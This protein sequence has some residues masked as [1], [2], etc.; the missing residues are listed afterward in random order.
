MR[1][2]TIDRA[3][4]RGPRLRTC[5]YTIVVYVRV[6]EQLLHGPN[7]V[8]VLEQVCREGV[9]ERV[10]TYSLDD[11]GLPRRPG[12][13]L[14]PTRGGETVSVVPIADRYRLERQETRTAIPIRR[15][16]S[17]TCDPA[18]TVTRRVQG[19]VRGRRGAHRLVRW[20]LSLRPACLE[21]SDARSAIPIS[22]CDNL[23]MVYSLPCGNRNAT[24]RA[25]LDPCVAQR[26]R[27]PSGCH[28]T[29]SVIEQK[30]EQLARHFLNRSSACSAL[31]RLSDQ[32]E[33][34]RR[35]RHWSSWPIRDGRVAASIPRTEKLTRARHWSVLP[36][37]K[38]RQSDAGLLRSVAPTRR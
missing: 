18:R 11:A 22:I 10:G 30:L 6:A 14:L 9:P 17:G 15:L 20:L 25:R 12:D 2:E 32:K 16:R 21:V 8:A 38:R 23:S 24:N 34:V 13:G 31:R 36:C 3:A 28:M 7:V 37:R 4:P 35:I 29:K 1:S 33:I 27:E 26:S 19:L 5:V